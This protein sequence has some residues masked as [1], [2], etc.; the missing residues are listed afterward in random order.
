MERSSKTS[1]PQGSAA[2]DLGEAIMLLVFITGGYIDGWAHNHLTITEG[3]FTPWHAVLYGGFA[4]SA[5]YA[6]VP[7][8][9]NM[10]AG[11]DVRR[12][13]PEGY[14]ITLVGIAVFAIAGLADLV[15]HTLFGVEANTEALISPPHITLFAGTLMMAA[16]PIR[17]TVRR[18]DPDRT[19]WAK[20]AAFVFLVLYV[21]LEM[22]FL[23]MIW[24]ITG[25]GDVSPVFSNSG[26]YWSQRVTDKEKPAE[27]NGDIGGLHALIPEEE[28][29][30]KTEQI[31]SFT[32]LLQRMGTS[33]VIVFAVIFSTAL[34]Y[35]VKI[36]R[37]PI[38]TFT[39]I[40]FFSTL[41][42]SLMRELSLPASFMVPQIVTGLVAGIVIDVLYHVLKPSFTRR[43]R[44]YGFAFAA[45]FAFIALLFLARVLSGGLWWSAPLVAGSCVY[46]GGIG[47]LLAIFGYPNEYEPRVHQGA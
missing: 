5:L 15:W 34:L 2:F 13:L 8:F 41:G 4:L 9:R 40:T 32:D 1:Y 20:N 29:A 17:S 21:V 37:I 35:I 47:L 14:D 7:A 3:F 25:S 31:T 42:I 36:G 28:R 24:P 6:L 43:A 30:G 10:R 46:A 45:P 23:M 26:P 16:G 39:V 44:L 33:T 22:G 27:I 11:Y 18:N 38:G 19:S 12:S